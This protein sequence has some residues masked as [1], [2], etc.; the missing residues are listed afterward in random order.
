MIPSNFA[1]GKLKKIIG[2][3]SGKTLGV[4]LF[5]IALVIVL[6]RPVAFRASSRLAGSDRFDPRFHAW[7][8][9]WDIHAL[10][11]N[12]LSLF[13][14]NI[15]F[16]MKNALAYSEHQII[17]GVLGIPFWLLSG[18]NPLFTLN[19]V[20]MLNF[21]IS[22]VAAYLLS[23]HLS[24]NRIA[25]LV[26]GIAYA[27]APY[28][29]SHISQLSICS[30]GWAPLSLLFLHRYSE[31]GRPF[32]ALLFSLFTLVQ[33]LANT[34]IGLFLTVAII[35]FFFVR[36]ITSRKT[37]TFRWIFW[38]VVF[39]LLAGVLLLPFAKPYLEV[40][41]D[42]R[43]IERTIDEVDL[44]SAD[45][46]DFLAAPQFNWIWGAITKHFRENTKG[47]G[48]P[49]HRSL[50]PGLVILVLAFTGA[51]TLYRKGKGEERF[52]LWYYSLLAVLTA[53]FSLGT[54]LYYFGGRHDIPMPYDVLYR[55]YPGFKALRVPSIFYVFTVLS[56]SVLAG[57]GAR[58][59]T[60]F[61]HN[62]KGRKG[63]AI[64]T[65]I[66]ISLLILEVMTAPLPTFKDKTKGSIPSVYRWLSKQSG[67][68]PTVELPLPRRYEEW[69]DM[70]SVRTYYSIF[71]WKKIVNGYSSFF[72]DT[73]R[74][75]LTLFQGNE[76]GSLIFKLKRQGVR[77]LIAESGY[78]D[79]VFERWLTKE[80]KARK[81]LRMFKR[82]ENNIVY[83]LL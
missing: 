14:A 53:I 12:P 4:L 52:S 27:F 36:F 81:N 76:F 13:N 56:L 44:H 34:Y 70:E 22:A 15:F 33:V 51:V 62:R 24:R 8:I 59:I 48:G 35:I 63:F 71:H 10:L 29:F 68:A 41:K 80:S 74:N 31:K 39:L 79:K 25:A 30:C 54:S 23:F 6:T 60:V 65:F 69:L 20:L 28:M 57:F 82:F 26:C 37:F 49:N 3:N 17:N 32:D 64:A 75:T 19:F 1:S 77:F 66:V 78:K 43:G 5:F 11:H 73:Y 55:I 58:E 18:G 83:E 38:I 67:D 2:G 21:L 47:R 46:Q 72:P 40:R 42:N 45:V 50:F 9:S 7:T 61:A 16:P